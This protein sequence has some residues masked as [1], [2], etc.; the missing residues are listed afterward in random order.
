MFWHAS[1]LPSINLSVHGGRGLPISHNA[2]Q[3]FPECHGADTTGGGG[4]YPYPIMLCNISQNAMGQTLAGGGS[5]PGPAR[6]GGTLPGGRYPAGGYPAGGVPCRGGGGCT[7]VGQQKEY[8]LHGGRYASCV[9]AGGLSC[10][11]LIRDC[12]TAE[13]CTFT[14][15]LAHPISILTSIASYCCTVRTPFLT[16]KMASWKKSKYL[17][18]F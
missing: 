9:H 17:T 8:S 2:L 13:W 10:K 18:Y 4:G 5:R 6:G 1:V 15:I 11:K 7:Q 12:Q 3:H 14:A 16:M